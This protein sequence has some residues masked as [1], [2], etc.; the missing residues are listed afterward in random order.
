MNETDGLCVTDGI[1]F[2]R[3]ICSSNGIISI[4]IIGV[5]KKYSKII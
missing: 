3:P 2:S 4:N 1:R 5:E